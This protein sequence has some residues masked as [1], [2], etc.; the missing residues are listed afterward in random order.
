MFSTYGIPKKHHLHT[1]PHRAQLLVYTFARPQLPPNL[2][3]HI[4]RVHK[5]GITLA[6]WLAQKIC[7]DLTINTSSNL[8]E[9]PGLYW[10]TPFAKIA[11]YIHR[12]WTSNS[13]VVL[14]P[15]LFS[16]CS[17]MWGNQKCSDTV[18]AWLIVRFALP[19]IWDTI[20]HGMEDENSAGCF[21]V[22]REC[23]LIKQSG[24][25]ILRVQIEQ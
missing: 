12:E 4:T 23:Q 18:V 13:I 3:Q 5:H 24:D 9:C 25:I 20:M 1:L 19:Q 7:N 2:R 6:E 11:P 10:K 22:I 8:L 15:Y 16:K 21:G 14:C 17:V